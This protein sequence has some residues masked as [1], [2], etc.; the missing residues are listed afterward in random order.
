MAIRTIQQLLE[1]FGPGDS[2]RSADYVD[3]IETLADDRNAVYFS[4]TAPEDTAA[5]PVWFRTDTQ[6][7]FVFNNGEWIGSGGETDLSSYYTKTQTDSQISSAV[8]AKADVSHTHASSE[9]TDLSSEISSAVSA[10]VDSAPETLDTLN[11]L[12]AALGDDPN[13]ATTVTNSIATKQDKVEGVSDTEIGYLD[14][15]T[16]EI[17]TQLNSKAV[18]PSQSSNAGKYLKTDGTAVSWDTVGGGLFPIWG[19][20]GGDPTTGQYFAFGNGSSSTQGILVAEATVVNSLAVSTTTAVTGT[21]VLEVYKNNVATGKT[22]SLTSGNTKAFAS[23]LNLSISANDTVSVFTVSGG[24]G[25][26]ATTATIWLVNAG[27]IGPQGPQGVPGI[28]RFPIVAERNGSPA[29]GTG[30]AFG[31]GADTTTLGGVSIPYNCTLDSLSITASTAFTG[32]FT[33]EAYKNGS[34][35][36]K[37]VSVLSGNTKG[38]ITGLNLSFVAGDTFLFLVTAGGVGGTVVRSAAWFIS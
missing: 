25:G 29:T 6:T 16:S 14:G 17:Q 7:L 27:A 8:S 21:L 12:A 10:L 4:A 13:F 1:K 15:V 2:P 38:F 28:T 34:S 3:L 26:G 37:T 9:I 33:I 18:Y 19:E 31:N 32:T 24:V 30:M 20:R 23:G 22:V 35:T 36:G 5:N 11:E